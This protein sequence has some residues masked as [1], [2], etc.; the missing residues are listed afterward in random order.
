M[1]FLSLKKKDERGGVKKRDREYEKQTHVL[2]GG[3]WGER[4][5]GVREKEE[6]NEQMV[7]YFC[8]LLFYE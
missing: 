2:K 6:K 3:S 7:L 8:L 1:Q 5:M 4:G